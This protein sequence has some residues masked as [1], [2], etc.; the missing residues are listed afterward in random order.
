MRP[1]N[2]SAS[3]RLSQI[4]QHLSRIDLQPCLECGRRRRAPLR[5]MSFE[6][7]GWT[8]LPAAAQLLLNQRQT[9]R[10]RRCPHRG[11]G[12]D[13]HD[14]RADHAL[15]AAMALRPRAS[16]CLDAPRS[17]PALRQ[18]RSAPSGAARAD[19]L[20]ARARRSDPL[21]TQI[22]HARGVRS[23]VHKSRQGMSSSN[24]NGSRLNE[25]RVEKGS[26]ESPS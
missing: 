5:D 9:I 14:D 12:Q 1:H 8:L 17:Q 16:T 13:E 26:V 21:P 3:A 10:T 18:W 22:H 6:H 11:D 24:F 2:Q 4:R 25:R 19:A 20:R 15:A 7:S 23:Q